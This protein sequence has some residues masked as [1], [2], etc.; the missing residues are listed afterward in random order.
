MKNLCSF[1]WFRELEGVF[2]SLFSNSKLEISDSIQA[3]LQARAVNKLE[4]EPAV[5]QELVRAY[6]GRVL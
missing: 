2:S 1:I 3:E 6:I 4:R 5:Q